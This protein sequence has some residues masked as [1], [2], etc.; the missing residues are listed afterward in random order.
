MNYYFGEE[1][2]LHCRGHQ[3]GDL[4]SNS[5]GFQAHLRHARLVRSQR[6]IAINCA[7]STPSGRS[8]KV[9]KYGIIV[10]GVRRRVSGM[11]LALLPGVAG[12]DKVQRQDSLA[13]IDAIS[14]Y[15]GRLLLAPVVE[16]NGAPAIPTGPPMA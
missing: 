13:A 8:P 12:E 6:A 7:L 5:C 9:F 3:G 4:V 16:H 2:R 10:S 15:G 11:F 14:H 1:S